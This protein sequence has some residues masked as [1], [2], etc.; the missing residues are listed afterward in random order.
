[1]A[2]ALVSVMDLAATGAALPA[3]DKVADRVVMD[4]VV[5]V[6]PVAMDPAARVV[7]IA[8]ATR[9]DP[10]AGRTKHQPSAPWSLAPFS[11]TTPNSNCS[12]V[13]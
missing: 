1:M 2:I 8:K 11:L 6:A 9:A 10:L 4:P 3:M 7:M 13:R 12:A 5:P